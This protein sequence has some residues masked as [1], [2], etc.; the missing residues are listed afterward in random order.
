MNTNELKKLEKDL[1]DI[2]DSFR[3]NTGLKSS[4][5]A[6]P[7]LGLIFLKFA[8]NRYSRYEEE[9]NDEFE[10]L[11]GSRREKTINE[12]AVEKSGF[13]LPEKA[14]YEYLLNLPEDANLAQA[15][16]EAMS[17]V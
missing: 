7:I 9:I 10:A 4:E 14:R 11:K 2:A 8:D 16:K 6:I 13:Y 3:A 12:I 5:Y 15:I 1:W 17:S